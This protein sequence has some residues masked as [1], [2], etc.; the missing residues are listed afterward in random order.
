MSISCPDV[1][2]DQHDANT[3][4]TFI[5][6]AYNEDKEI[7]D[8]QASD[9]L[10][11]SSYLSRSIYGNNRRIWSYGKTENNSILILNGMKEFFRTKGINFK[12]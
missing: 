11:L 1:H 5:E 10:N 6:Y 12:I 2:I 4:F 9:M 3:L 8:K 7:F